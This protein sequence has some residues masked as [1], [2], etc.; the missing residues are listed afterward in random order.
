MSL[1]SN[2]RSEY[3]YGKDNY[4]LLQTVRMI[5]SELKADPQYKTND[6]VESKADK[7]TK[8]KGAAGLISGDR[9]LN[10]LEKAWDETTNEMKAMQ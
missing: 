4:P 3:E 8:A 9:D 7:K 2:I 5:E 1:R 10:N 6:T